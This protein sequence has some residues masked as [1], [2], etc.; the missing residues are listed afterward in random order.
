M[1]IV[2]AAVALVVT[3]A[4]F[5][6]NPTSNSWMAMPHS[7]TETWIWAMRTLLVASGLLMDHKTVAAGIAL[8]A[9]AMMAYQL[10]RW[11]RMLSV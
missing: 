10:L 1:A 2:F 4:D 11:V 3:L 9:T 7:A 6:L 5:E 8:V